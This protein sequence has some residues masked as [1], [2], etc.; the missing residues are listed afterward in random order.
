MTA[1]M[2]DGFLLNDTKFSVAGINGKGLFNPEQ[3]GLHPVGTCTACW[4]GYVCLYSLKD[5]KLL[6]DELELSLVDFNGQEVASTVGPAINGVEP[7][8]P[9]NEHAIFNNIYKN[10]NLNIN[11]TGGLLIGR[12]FIRE[13]YVHMG[14]HPAW[15]YR[16]VFELVFEEGILREKRDMSKAM[17]EFRETMA[18]YPLRPGFEASEEM[19]KAW[20]ESTFSLDYR[21]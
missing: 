17:Q 8:V 12:E 20:I 4:R 13:L 16:E 5:D 9:K 10:L 3:F 6:L 2:S 19:L 18:K 11:F 21:F 15:K 1:Q 14:F 7:S